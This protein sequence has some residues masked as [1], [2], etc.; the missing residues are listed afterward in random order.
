MPEPEYQP[1]DKSSKWLIQHHGDSMLRLAEIGDIET[2]RPVQAEVVQPR[3]L[4]DGLLEARLRGEDRDSLFLLEVA[5]YP[6]RRVAEQLTR[7]LMLV[8]LDRGELPEAVTLVLRPKGRYRVASRRNLR[9]PHGL[10]SFSAKWRV[11]ELWTV[12]GERLLE[13]QDVGLVPWLPLTDFA[14]PPETVI[15]RCR[16]IIDLRAPPGEKANLLAVAQVLTRLRYND[17]G[18]LSTLLG[19]LGGKEIMIESPLIQELFDERLR[20]VVT[21]NIRATVQQNILAVL[22]ARFGEVPGDV[23]EPIRSIVDEGRLNAL[24]RS[25]ASCPDLEAFRMEI[26]R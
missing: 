8:Y 12:P 25:A 18:L 17:A 20:E 15:R 5:T 16:D 24:V 13:S 2:W 23:A 19:M 22:E 9:S 6:E 3:Q 21:E 11:V 14:S 1:Y 4:P 10:S 7:D 26:K